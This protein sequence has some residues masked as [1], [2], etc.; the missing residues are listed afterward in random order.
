M[1]AFPLHVR[2]AHAVAA[3]DFRVRPHLDRLRIFREGERTWGLILLAPAFLRRVH[4]KVHLAAWERGGETLAYLGAEEA[5]FLPA[6]PAV[7]V[8]RGPLLYFFFPS[9]PRCVKHPDGA[10]GITAFSNRMAQS[11]RSELDRGN[12]LFAHRHPP[13]E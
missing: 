3:G 13:L 5:A 8:V 10:V 7:Y 1:C 11:L 2:E 9:A 12:E 4:D 6:E